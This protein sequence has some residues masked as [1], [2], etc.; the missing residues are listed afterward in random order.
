MRP[1]AYQAKEHHPQ[2]EM[3]G[4]W[5]CTHSHR[6]NASEEHRG[7]PRS[8]RKKEHR[9]GIPGRNCGSSRP[10]TRSFR[11]QKVCGIKGLGGQR[12]WRGLQGFCKGLRGTETIRGAH[13]CGSL[14]ASGCSVPFRS[15]QSGRFS[16][17]SQKGALQWKH[18]RHSTACLFHLVS[19]GRSPSK[20]EMHPPDG[21]LC[22]TTWIPWHIRPMMIPTS[23]KHDPLFPVPR[24]NI[25]LRSVDPRASF[26]HEQHPQ[27]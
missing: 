20:E 16:G 1:M 4:S 11:R 15:S 10:D 12:F 23:W 27:P 24:R 6:A 7:T 14:F 19:S 9:T 17:S 2:A 21:P 13:V 3:E 8:P 18:G 5:L 26:H 22:L 25:L